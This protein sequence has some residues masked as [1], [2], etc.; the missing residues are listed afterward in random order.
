MPADDGDFYQFCYVTSSGLVRGTSM[1][2]QFHHMNNYDF[3]TE[4]DIDDDMMV[5]HK[6]SNSFEGELKKAQEVSFS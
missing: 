2:C 1:P 3:V 5:I 6:R 4:E